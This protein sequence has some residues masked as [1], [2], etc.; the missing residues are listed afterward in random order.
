MTLVN[1]KRFVFRKIR[2]QGST[3]CESTLFKLVSHLV[4]FMLWSR[5]SEHT[6]MMH[7]FTTHHI[8]MLTT[9][10][11]SQL[12]IWKY[13]PGVDIDKGRFKTL[14]NGRL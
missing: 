2:Q 14:H 9:T 3:T 6:L 1:P 8:T 12:L 10:A 5:H 11:M 7:T 4:D 13:R